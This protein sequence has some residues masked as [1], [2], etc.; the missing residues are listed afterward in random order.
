MLTKIKTTLAAT[1]LLLTFSTAPS[2]SQESPNC[3][4]TIEDALIHLDNQGYEVIESI[5]ED[6]LNE[7]IE[8]NEPKADF[9]KRFDEVHI[10]KNSE[11]NT[12]AV[13]HALD[14]CHIIT[15]RVM[16]SSLQFYFDWKN[17]V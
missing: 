5:Y 7:F 12:F 4:L 9:L 6:N 13:S 11:L 8:Q 17:G 15:Q 3:T 10:V 14:G 1:L 2:V 16:E